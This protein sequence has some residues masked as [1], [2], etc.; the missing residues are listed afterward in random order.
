MVRSLSLTFVIAFTAELAAAQP[1]SPIAASVSQYISSST[2]PP[3]RP[4]W[5][6]P[7]PL[8]TR[9]QL[10]T[11]KLGPCGVDNQKSIDKLVTFLRTNPA[12]EYAL[13]VVPGAS[14]QACHHCA[15]P[16]RKPDGHWVDPN[17]RSRL[18]HAFLLLLDGVVHSVLISGGSI[19]AQYRQYDEA[20]YGLREMLSEYGPRFAQRV[21]GRLEERLI[22]DPWAIHSEVN[23]RNG[24]RLTRMLGLERNLIVTEVGSMKRQGWWFVNHKQQIPLVKWE[25]P[26]SFDAI[27][28]KRFGYA[29][30]E[31]EELGQAPI[32]K[33]Y[34]PRSAADRL[35][36][37]PA[38][39]TNS[40][41]SHPEIEY[42]LHGV[43]TAAIAHFGLRTL[44]ELM[45]GGDARWDLGPLDGDFSKGPMLPPSAADVG[46][47]CQT[48]TWR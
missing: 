23:V 28:R 10:Y 29:L 9:S 16:Y 13:A 3:A 35:G 22:V 36:N 14:E 41:G 44:A 15:W 42:V 30:G 12:M 34:L 43:D 45:Q 31:F 20:I 26:W 25:M 4:A 27:S 47:A 21:G 7:D 24:D 32:F 46:K 17:F 1:A 39:Y 8:L 33:R 19:D 37:H 40:A 11:F 48:A 38:Q 5:K 18:R 6:G 2:R